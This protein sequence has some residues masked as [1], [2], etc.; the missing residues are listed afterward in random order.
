MLSSA[1][2][3]TSNDQQRLTTTNNNNNALRHDTQKHSPK[4]HNF[5]TGFFHR[6]SRSPEKDKAKDKQHEHVMKGKPSM[7]SSTDLPKGNAEP[8][9]SGFVVSEEQLDMLLVDID[10]Y[11]SL[12]KRQIGHISQKPTLTKSSSHKQ[13]QNKPPRTPKTDVRKLKTENVSLANPH[14]GK[15]KLKILTDCLH[16]PEDLTDCLHRPEDLCSGHGGNTSLDVTESTVNRL[17]ADQFSKEHS[18][19]TTT[20]LHAGRGLTQGLSVD[21]PSPSRHRLFQDPVS[22]S[23]VQTPSRVPLTSHSH[24]VSFPVT[25]DHVTSVPMTS[26]HVTRYRRPRS[27]GDAY[28]GMLESPSSSSCI[29]D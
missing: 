3:V 4:K 17:V 13:H 19:N 18:R 7:T 20:S 2:S 11:D 23:S 15:S 28:D 24:V 16:R 26:Y 22:S 10:S 8:S 14:S 6:K 5:V 1:S 9:R 27:D 21:L 29:S 25:S 12:G